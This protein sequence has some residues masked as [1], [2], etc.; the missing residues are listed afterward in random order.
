MSPRRDYN[1]FQLD[2]YPRLAHNVEPH[3]HTKSPS[4]STI[5]KGDAPAED[6]DGLLY[7]PAIDDQ[8]PP[9]DAP[10][11]IVKMAMDG[12]QVVEGQAIWSGLRNA[13]VGRG[14]VLTG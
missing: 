9:K 4:P 6:E 5:I 12:V 7:G 2:Y 8:C 14:L 3:T 13:I 10:F 1:R 11:S